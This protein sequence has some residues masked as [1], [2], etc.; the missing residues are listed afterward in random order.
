V[1]FCLKPSKMGRNNLNLNY[2][3]LCSY[4]SGV[5]WYRINGSSDC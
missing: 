5:N 4:E 3:R 2:I 1:P